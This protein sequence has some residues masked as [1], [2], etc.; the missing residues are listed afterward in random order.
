MFSGLNAENVSFKP[1]PDSLYKITLDNDLWCVEAHT[2]PFTS[3]PPKFKIRAY[4]CKSRGC[5]LGL[6]YPTYEYHI[7]M[8][9]NGFIYPQFLFLH[10]QDKYEPKKRD[11]G[12]WFFRNHIRDGFFHSIHDFKHVGDTQYGPIIEALGIKYT[13]ELRQIVYRIYIIREG[14]STDELGEIYHNNY[15]LVVINKSNAWTD[16]SRAF[17]DEI[18]HSIEQISPVD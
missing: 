8:W 3:I 5:L 17:S 9:W 2:I 13:G 1:T 4:G 10:C 16:I 11:E 18:F 6:V 15:Y 12:Y 7:E 14:V